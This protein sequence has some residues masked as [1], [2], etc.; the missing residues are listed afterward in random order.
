MYVFI[1]YPPLVTTDPTLGDGEVTQIPPGFTS[2]AYTSNC[3]FAA[4]EDQVGGE[5]WDE[6]KKNERIGES[7]IYQNPNMYTYI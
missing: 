3:E 7:P 1:S 6:A 2:I 4:V 5:R